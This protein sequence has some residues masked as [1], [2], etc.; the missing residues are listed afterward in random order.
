MP[1]NLEEVIAEAGNPQSLLWESQAPPIVS[2]PSTPEFTNWRDEQLAWRQTAVLF[3][4]CHHMVD[5]NMKGPDA[6]RLIQD[7]ALNSTEYFPIDAAKQ[8]VAVN[9]EGLLIGD[10]ILFRLEEDEFHS[11]GLPPTIN[12]LQYHAET[13][14]YDVDIWRD[15]PSY[16]RVGDPVLYRYEVQGPGALNVIREATGAEPPQVKFFHGARL[17][18]AGRMVRVLRHGMVAEPG[19]ELFGPWEDNDAVLGAL[20]KAGEKHGLVKVGGRAYLTTGIESGWL[21]RPLPAFYSGKSTEGFRRWLAADDLD[22]TA[23]LG[24]SFYSEDIED[25][26]FSPFDLG[27]GR[28][29]KL[30][31]DFIGRSA[32][33]Q[34]IADGRSEANRKVTLVWNADDVEGAFGSMLRPGKGAKYMNLP[35]AN[36]ATYQYDRVESSDGDYV[37]RSNY[38]GYS[39]NERSMLS[40]AVVDAALAE[41]GTEVVL[42]WG[43]PTPSSKP[44]VEDHVQV[45]IRATVQPAP[46]APKARGEYRSNAAVA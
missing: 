28:V 21:P 45:K 44:A 20:L 29:L 46:L 18:I 37:G 16:A 11:V 33:E 27:Y 24:G 38:A 42:V 43:E 40:I 30:D 25:Y 9:E 36:Y 2:T 35:I 32:L 19:F 17:S 34:Q 22:A 5:L 31:H 15:N 8:Y 13:G 12:W 10:N 3:D 7:T 1:S 26:Y 14:G 4:Q 6:L 39:A 23:A 41:P